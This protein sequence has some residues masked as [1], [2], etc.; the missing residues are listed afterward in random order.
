MKKFSVVVS[1]TAIAAGLAGGAVAFQAVSSAPETVAVARTTDNLPPA[2]QVKR[3]GVKF[4]FAPC[5]APATRVGKACVIDVVQTV[6]VAAPVVPVGSESRSD[7]G[8]DDGSADGP[9]TPNPAAHNG[10]DG[11]DQGPDNASDDD[12]G[13]DHEAEDED[14]DEEHEADEPGE[15]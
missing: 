10:G 9:E 11:D 4:R 7:D 3:P 2:P 12:E 14:E 1:A 13:E 15:D 6:V 5:K 8:S